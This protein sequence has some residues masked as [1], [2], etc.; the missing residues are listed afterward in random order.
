MN[1]DRWLSTVKNV[2]GNVNIAVEIG[3]WNADYSVKI[4]NSLSPKQFYGIDPY[5]QYDNAPNV[6]AYETAAKLEETYLKAAAKLPPHGKIIRDFSVNAAE[7]FEDESIDFV[8]IDGDHN[9]E[10]VTADIKA[11]YPKIK[12]GGIISGHDYIEKNAKRN[13][14]F[15]VIPAVTEF[16]KEYNKNISLTSEAYATWWTIK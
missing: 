13:I 4:C 16:S 1:R 8:Y 10:A 12:S 3:V 11:W 7:L 15:G 9:Y 6:N 14:V 5:V 2:L